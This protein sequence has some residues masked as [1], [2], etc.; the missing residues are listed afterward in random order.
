MFRPGAVP[1]LFN[2]FMD[3]ESVKVCLCLDDDGKLSLEERFEV[4]QTIK[5]MEEGDGSLPYTVIG[6]VTIPAEIPYFFIIFKNGSS[7]VYDLV[8]AADEA[9]AKTKVLTKKRNAGKRIDF[10]RVSNIAGLISQYSS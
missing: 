10:K 6:S 1:G 4:D 3:K 8:Q 9:S 2:L 7:I 5:N